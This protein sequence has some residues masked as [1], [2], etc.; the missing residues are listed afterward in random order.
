MF[1][2]VHYMMLKAE[3]P[4][5]VQFVNNKG[6]DQCYIQDFEKLYVLLVRR[7]LFLIKKLYIP[8]K[9]YMKTVIL[10][11]NVTMT[12]QEFP[13]IFLYTRVW[14]ALIAP[15]PSG[16]ERLGSCGSILMSRFFSESI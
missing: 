6:H 13:S 1:D 5:N 10:K 7:L 15:K 3:Y 4:V 9:S 2:E 16:I 14:S 8:E 11:P 12:K